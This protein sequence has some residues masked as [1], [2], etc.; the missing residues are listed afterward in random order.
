MGPWGPEALKALQLAEPCRVESVGLSLLPGS[1]GEKGRWHWAFPHW[2]R[3]RR[4]LNATEGW[5]RKHDHGCLLGMCV[6]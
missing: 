4:P 2:C 3:P 5:S 1:S 6:F